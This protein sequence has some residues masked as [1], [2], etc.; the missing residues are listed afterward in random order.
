MIAYTC[1]LDLS[2]QSQ[3]KWL[4]YFDDRD[5]HDHVILPIAIYVIVLFLPIAIYLIVLF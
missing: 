5:L 1:M 3:F 2:R 4:C